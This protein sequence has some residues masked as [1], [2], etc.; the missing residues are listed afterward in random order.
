MISRGC[1]AAD[2]MKGHLVLLFL[3]ITGFGLPALV[4]KAAVHQPG[5]EAT[6]PQAILPN[7]DD[8][9]SVKQHIPDPDHSAMLPGIHHFAEQQGKNSI[10]NLTD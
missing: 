4:L 5:T 7:L 3:F 8:I 1:Y 2:I 10:V 6:A 9:A